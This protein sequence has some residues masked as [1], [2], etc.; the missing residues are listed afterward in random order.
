MNPIAKQ[1]HEGE[2]VHS[3]NGV[4]YTFVRPVRANQPGYD[5][6]VEVMD[7]KGGKWTFYARVFDLM[8]K[9]FPFLVD[10][11]VP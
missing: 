5:G 11:E 8:V 7:A 10:K 9:E 3:F 1:V 6:K 4:N 2:R